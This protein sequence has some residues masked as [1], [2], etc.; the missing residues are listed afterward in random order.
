MPPR[1]DAGARPVT[2][3]GR[4]RR[5][6]ITAV[7]AELFH[8]HGYEA[9]TL[10][11]VARRVN[12]TAPALYRH[13]S[14]KEQLLMATVSATLGYGESMLVQYAGLDIDALVEPMIDVGLERREIWTLV[15]REVRHLD[16]D[17]R[18][19]IAGRYADVVRAVT[20]SISLSR[21]DLTD[22]GA[23]LVACAVLSVAGSPSSDPVDLPA[24]RYRESLHNAARAL[25]WL[26]TSDVAEPGEADPPEDEHGASVD[27]I[28]PRSKTMVE[29]AAIR[30][31]Y[32]HGYTAVTVDDIGAAAGITG[33]S[34]Y[35][36]VSSKSELLVDVMA[37]AVGL[38]AGGAR[39]ALSQGGTTDDRLRAL[40]RS[41]CRVAASN[42]EL[43]GVYVTEAN[44]VPT[45][46]ARRLRETMAR[47]VDRW[48][49]AVVRSRA[50]LGVDEV[51]VRVFVAR[52]VVIDMVRLERTGDERL[53]R[54]T[55][56][57]ALTVLL[58][59]ENRR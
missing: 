5:D 23:H 47:D 42:R 24:G 4:A 12:L 25:L 53:A 44:N 57:L 37:R 18:R 51:R 8:R 54:A 29:D 2:R 43:F 27:T 45:G 11:D 28:L 39:T 59:R 34:V 52:R 14:S 1:N 16:P 3:R 38:V 30:L 32:R 49:E 26:D 40:V 15:Q 21:P 19:E 56:T 33:P 31:F 46:D 13:F 58:G 10:A 36:Y 41:Y 50:D 48:V 22:E 17:D 7:A 35:H 9:V 20:E 6:Q 55:E